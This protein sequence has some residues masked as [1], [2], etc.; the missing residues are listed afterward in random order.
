MNIY[1]LK[2]CLIIS[3]L[4]ISRGV[5]CAQD[6]NIDEL[7]VEDTARARIYYLE[8]PTVVD[9]NSSPALTNVPLRQRVKKSENDL[10]SSAYVEN[11]ERYTLAIEMI[12]DTGGVWDSQLVEQLSTLGDLQQQGLNHPAAID[13]YRRAIQINRISQGLHTPDQIP[14]LENMIDSFV[15]TEEWEQADLYSDYLFFVQ[16]KA[17]G[18]NDPRLIPALE[19]YAKL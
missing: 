18:I 13:A 14:F 3:F 12:E 10:P 19:R 17:Y 5:L 4:T 16:H 1:L 7:L 8:K 11:I 2:L 6:E 15:A 9:S